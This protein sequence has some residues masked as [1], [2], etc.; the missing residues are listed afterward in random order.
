MAR[1]ETAEVAEALGIAPDTL[2]AYRRQSPPHLRAP[3]LLRELR[4][5]ALATWGEPG[6]YLV[7]CATEHRIARSPKMEKIWEKVTAPPRAAIYLGH[8]YHAFRKGFMSGL[9]ELGAKDTAVDYLVGHVMP[10]VQ[11]SYVD[12]R[13]LQLKDAVKLV[14]AIKVG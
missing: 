3:V 11:A 10:G 2:L 14:P 9:L 6:G 7:P 8:P 12:P 4:R 1:L 13:A 5:P